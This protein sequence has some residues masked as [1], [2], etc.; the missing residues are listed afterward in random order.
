MMVHL[1]N[2]T[3]VGG[4][5]KKKKITFSLTSDTSDLTSELLDP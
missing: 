4:K 3:K 2:F 1:Y 5:I